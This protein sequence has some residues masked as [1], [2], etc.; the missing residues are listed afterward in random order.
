M[1][2]ILETKDF[3]IIALLILAFAGG[4]AGTKLLGGSPDAKILSRIRMLER[5][6]DAIIGH[7]GIELPDALVNSGLS[8]E[9]CSLAD[10]GEKISAIK[11]HRQETG[12]GLKEAKDAVEAYLGQ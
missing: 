1:F 7:L 12:I 2:A 5:K 11:L 10:K 9:V 8:P 6:L 4:T 3:A